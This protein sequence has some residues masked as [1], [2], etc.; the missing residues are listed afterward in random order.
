MCAGKKKEFF[1]R[2]K[3]QINLYGFEKLYGAVSSDELSFMKCARVVVTF[4][5]LLA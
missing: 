3:Y 1:D 4:V 5:T 2:K